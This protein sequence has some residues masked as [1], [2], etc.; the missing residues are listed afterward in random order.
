MQMTHEWS[1]SRNEEQSIKTEMQ[2]QTHAPKSEET[3]RKRKENREAKRPY[4]LG[5]SDTF[6]S[7]EELKNDGSKPLGASANGSDDCS[8]ALLKADAEPALS[9]APDAAE[10]D[11]ELVVAPVGTPSIWWWSSPVADVSCGERCER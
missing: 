5:A 9:A 11:V 3:Q 4:L 7:P 8:L 2:R 10:L 6:S 1:R